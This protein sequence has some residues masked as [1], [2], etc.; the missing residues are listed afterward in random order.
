MID[1]VKSFHI[2]FIGLHSICKLVQGTGWCWGVEKGYGKWEWEMNN[3]LI[4]ISLYEKKGVWY[5]MIHLMV[6]CIDE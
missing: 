4:F 5:D 3:F 1:Q 6:C 2:M